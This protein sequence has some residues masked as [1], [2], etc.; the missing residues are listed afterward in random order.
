MKY[1][2]HHLQWFWIKSHYAGNSEWST[3]TKL[4]KYEEALRKMNQGKF[5]NNP[6]YGLGEQKTLVNVEDASCSLMMVI[7]TE[8]YDDLPYPGLMFFQIPSQ[9]VLQE[10]LILDE[11][12]EMF[13]HNK[14]NTNIICVG[15]II[16]DASTESSIDKNWCLRNI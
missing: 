14:S 5:G 9:E 10:E 6:P 12:K 7:P 11:V 8:E 16:L 2:P 15:D 4:K 13:P 1:L 3:Q